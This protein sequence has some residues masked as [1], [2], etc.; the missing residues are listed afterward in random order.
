MNRCPCLVDAFYVSPRK[1][2]GE[3]LGE[4]AHS[5]D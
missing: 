2:L 4:W 1:S 5:L 3:A